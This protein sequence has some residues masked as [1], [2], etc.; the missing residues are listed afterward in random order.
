[1]CT[2]VHVRRSEDNQQKFS[3]STIWALI[4]WPTAALLALIIEEKA[5]RMGREESE[6]SPQGSRQEAVW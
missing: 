2:M 4:N 3:L 5:I 6:L 1:M